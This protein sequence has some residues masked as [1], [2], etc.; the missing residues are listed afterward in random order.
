MASR[1][2]AVFLLFALVLP[3]GKKG[4][5]TGRGENE[6]VIL[7]ITLYATPA[8]IK[9]LLGN[10]LDG[11]YIVAD[12]KV[13]PKY[14]KEIAIDRDD[15]KLRTD[16]DGSR[17]TPFAASQIAGQ[18]ALIVAQT[19]APASSPGMVGL[20]GPMI[21]RGG[22]AGV[23]SGNSDNGQ[24]RATARNP[25]MDK[26]NPLEKLLASKILPEKKT[27]QPVSGLLYFPMEKQKAKDLE[28][29]YGGKENRI[30]IRFK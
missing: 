14:G 30:S 22:G 13:E 24:V 27:E 9:E 10:D 28:L 3:A 18:G 11:H 17:T 20:G 8:A 1:L 25:A 19:E 16:K 29:D 26:E 4:P 21:V 5:P 7:T 6:D 23:G 2:F 12:V 15:F